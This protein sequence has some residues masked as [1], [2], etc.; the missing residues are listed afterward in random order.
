[1]YDDS[2]IHEIEDQEF[3]KAWRDEGTKN[4]GVWDMQQL[5]GGL[6]HCTD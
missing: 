6:P 2:T 3:I 1:M 5:F 4:Q